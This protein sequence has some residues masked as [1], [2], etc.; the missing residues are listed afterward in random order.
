[1]ATPELL[2]FDHP[3][4]SYA[5]K[6]R[7]A[8]REKRLPFKSEVPVGASDPPPAFLKANPRM[9]V[10]TLMHGEAAIFDSTIILEYLEDLAPEPAALPPR[11]D[12]AAR[13]RLRMIEDVA[14]TQYEAINWVWGE[15]LWMA[16]A[17]EGSKLREH[18]HAQVADQTREIFA[19]FEEKLKGRD[20]FGGAYG[21]GWADM[22]VVPLVHRSMYY[23]FGPEEGSVLRK[24]HDRC[25]ERESVRQ[26]LKEFDDGV[27]VM[28]QAREVFQSGKK[29]REYRDHR[30]EAMLKLG[31]F[32]IVEE[33]IRKKNIRFSWPNPEGVQFEG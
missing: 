15:V 8:L 12:P 23:G 28:Y 3:V 5:Q 25:A 19:W 24:W 30:L 2:L 9:E 11:S 4:S 7:I 32:P 1:M 10:P 21:F 27:E 29:R 18:L 20:F 13:A 22:A 17:P 16:R 6:V 26:T 14:D 31:G 33:G